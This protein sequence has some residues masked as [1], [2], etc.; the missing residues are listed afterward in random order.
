MSP[1]GHVKVQDEKE[2]RCLRLRFHWRRRCRILRFLL[3]YIA[4]DA[5]NELFFFSY[6]NL[7]L[8]YVYV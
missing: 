8:W 5:I 7:K 4:S 3:T 1:T 2:N 6:R